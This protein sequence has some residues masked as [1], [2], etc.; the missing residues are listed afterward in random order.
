M[1]PEKSNFKLILIVFT[2]LSFFD[3][4]VF[5]ISTEELIET[6]DGISS[7]STLLT[8]EGENGDTI[9]QYFYKKPGFIKMVFV[10][11]HEGAVLVYNPKTQKVLLTP[12]KH[13]GALTIN[14]KPDSFLITDPKGH[15]VDQ[16]DMGA[17]LKNVLI[18]SKN[19]NEKIRNKAVYNDTVCTVLSVKAKKGF[20]LEGIFQYLLW[21]DTKIKLPV[22]VESYDNEFKLLE[23]VLMDDLKV[24]VEFPDN[25]F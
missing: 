22:R 16:S 19:G 14:L 2:V 21:V 9:V 13:L 8:S 10:K 17:L 23:K 18:L 11:P 25:F 24:N 3:S 20:D 5:A 7:Y 12:F 6:F 15:T 1:S 4:T